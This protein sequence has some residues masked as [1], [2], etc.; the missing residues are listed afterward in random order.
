MEGSRRCA[1]AVMMLESRPPLRKD[2]T[3]TSAT[4][5]AATDCSRPRE[6][7]RRLRAARAAT[8]AGSQYR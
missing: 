7:L 6:V 2:A 4:R 1:S 3:G 5:C 8:S